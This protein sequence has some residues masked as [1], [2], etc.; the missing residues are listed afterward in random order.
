MITL[1]YSP[2][3]Q[4]SRRVVSLLEQL[5]LPYDPQLVDMMKGEYLS[6]DYLAI[7]PNHQVPT[8]ID[9]QITIHESNAILR[10]LCVKHQLT[11]W[12]PAA[13]ATRALVE[14][15]LDWTQCRM[16]PAVVDIVL[17]KVFMGEHGD[18]QAI[19]RGRERMG[20]LTVILESALADRSYLAADHPTIADLA[21]ASN[22][23]HLGLADEAPATGNIHHWY[24]R[25]AE[26]PGFQRSLPVLNNE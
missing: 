16:S 18:Q 13:P 19:A 4:H 10:Y 17:N 21:L 25:V 24:T 23:F 22:I 3:S 5:E 7:N 11:D 9:G 14:Q 15:W 1:Y 2:L 8:L 26:L 12:Y 20:E 6:D